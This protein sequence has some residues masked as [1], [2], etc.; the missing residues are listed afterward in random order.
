M[1]VTLTDVAVKTRKSIRWG[2]YFVAFILVARFALSSARSIKNTFFPAPPPP[3]TVGFDVLSAIPFPKPTQNLPQL[4]VS[5]ETPTGTLPQFPE[6]LPVYFMPKA[7]PTLSSVDTAKTRARNLGFS[8]EPI[9]ISQTVY[10]FN[11]PT[12]PSS[13]TMN[14]V[15]ETFSIAYD[16]ASDPSPIQKNPPHPEAAVSQA[17]TLLRNANSLPQDLSGP[18]PHEFLKVESQKLVQAISLSDADLIKINLYRKDFGSEENPIPV[19]TKDPNEANI[20]FILSGTGQM[21]AAEYHYYRIDEEKMHTYPIKSAAQ[22]LEDLKMGRGYIANLGLNQD[23]AVTIR[24]IY[25]AYYDP[26]VSTEFFQP[27]IVFEGDD[28]FVAYVP[29]VTDTYYEVSPA[30]TES[31]EAEPT[32]Q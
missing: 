3:P 14:I 32:A 12:S 9:E 30:P 29:A 25:L 18:T 27:V 15:W 17:K 28:N 7:L 19:V 31:P 23:G 26:D 13:L 2:I 10:R 8:A 24:D 21:V 22:A 11:H 20:W 1:A 16:L 5:T 6:S 4:S